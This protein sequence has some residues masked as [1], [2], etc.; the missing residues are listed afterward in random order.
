MNCDPIPALKPQTP[1]PCHSLDSTVHKE[2]DVIA[3]KLTLLLP[4][5]VYMILLLTFLALAL[6]VQDFIRVDMHLCA[7]SAL[8]ILVGRHERHPACKYIW[9]FVFCLRFDWSSAQHVA[10]V[11][12]TTSIIFSSNKIQHGDNLVPGNTGHLEKWPLN[13]R[14]MHLSCAGKWQISASNYDLQFDSSWIQI[15]Q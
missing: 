11:F 12:T 14:V 8:T 9:V 10:P 15:I 7:F 2:H 3:F 6:S 1:L 5:A 4:A 13:W